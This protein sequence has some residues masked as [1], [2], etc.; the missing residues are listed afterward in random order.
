M[1]SKAVIHNK[2]DIIVRDAETMK[3]IQRGKAENIVLDRIYTKLCNF[4]SY[5]TTIVFGSGTGTPTPDRTTLFSRVGSKP[6]VNEEIIRAYPTSKWTRSIR[7]GT[8]E[9]NGNTITEVGISETSTEINTH[10]LITDAENNPL[11]VVKTDLVIV[12]IYA[13]VYIE[14][15]NVDSG[16]FYAGNGWRD[17]LAG[18]G[19]LGNTL[20]IAASP[21]RDD[22]ADPEYGFS[23]TGTRV[24]DAANKRVS[25]STRFQENDLNK[26]I[27]SVM[28]VNTGLAVNLPR[29]GVFEG[30]QKNDV[31]VGVGDGAEMTF[32]LPNALIENLAVKVDD[33]PVSNWTLKGLNAI[34]FDAPVTEG[35]IVTASY[36]SKLIPKDRDHILD[37]SFTLQY[38]NQGTLPTPIIPAPDFSGV[39]GGQEPIAGSGEYGFYGEVSA[40]ELISGDELCSLLGLSSGYSQN[41]DSGWLKVV[42]GTKML[43]I[44]KKTIRYSISWDSINAAEAVFGKIIKIDGKKYIARLLSTA[45]W[46]RYMYP[47][48]VDHPGGAPS[49]AEYTNVDL[50]VNSSVAGNGTRTWT[51]TVGSQS[52]YRVGRGFGSVSHSGS[53]AS[54]GASSNYGFRPVLEVYF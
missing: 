22:I 10:A 34:E 24:A 48:H 11:S 52:S 26:D 16:L 19:S 8:L 32:P 14:I 2:F 40:E 28:W 31:Q 54:S 9:Y 43:L 51:S 25:V 18:G 50:H 13:T 47:L 15:P 5:F 41:S 37:V 38:D 23:R 49:W 27:A 17:Y 1:Q 6:A 20:K 45:E 12:D 7:L 39:P 36:L 21:P 3:E 4:N 42:D 53:L 46:D 35:S 29:A 33:S 30:K 44:A